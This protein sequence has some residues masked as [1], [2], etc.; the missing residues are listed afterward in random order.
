MGAIFEDIDQG[1][2]TM[3][4]AMDK[5]GLELTFEEM[6]E[7]HGEG[8]V[9]NA[10]VGQVRG[11]VDEGGKVVHQG[12]NEER[13]KVFNEENGPPAD[14]G[15]E[16]LKLKGITI[17]DALG[18]QGLTRLEGFVVTGETLTLGVVFGELLMDGTENIV[19][20]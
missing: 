4:E 3:G 5:E 15:P 13:T 1:H 10:T 7:D 11:I 6:K 9:L 2:G 8:S 18:S 12:V 19:D 17:L 16:I 20:I 14:L